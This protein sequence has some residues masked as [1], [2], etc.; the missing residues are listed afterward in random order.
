MFIPHVYWDDL[1]GEVRASKDGALNTTCI[2]GVGQ[3][4]PNLKAYLCR[5]KVNISLTFDRPSVLDQSCLAMKA[6]EHIV[7]AGAT[8]ISG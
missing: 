5:P 4:K 6:V 2:G 7:E 3:P 1:A 8:P